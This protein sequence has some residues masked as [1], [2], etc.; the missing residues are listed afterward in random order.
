MFLVP[1]DDSWVMMGFL[2]DVP[3]FYCNDKERF[4]K[5]DKGG[6]IYELE[7]HGFICYPD[8]GMGDKEWVSKKTLTP[9]RKTIYNSGLE[10]MLEN[11]VTVRF[12]KKQQFQRI[13]GIRRIKE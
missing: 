2:G 11:G 5:L 7:C 12:M 9:L 8:K 3:Y 13:K 1:S 10:A 4:L 6:A